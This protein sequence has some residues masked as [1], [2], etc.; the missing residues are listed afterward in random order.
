MFVAALQKPRTTIPLPQPQYA[1]RLSGLSLVVAFWRTIR[2]DMY[3]QWQMDLNP[4][5]T[6][7]GRMWVS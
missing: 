1:F 7:E 5:W 3:L 2:V 4:Q 6:K